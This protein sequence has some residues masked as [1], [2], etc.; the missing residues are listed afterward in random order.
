MGEE[1]QTFRVLHDGP[2]PID[3]HWTPFP[4]KGILATSCYINEYCATANAT[5]V[6]LGLPRKCGILSCSGLNILASSLASR[7]VRPL[8]HGL[9]SENREET[10]QQAIFG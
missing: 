2:L 1:V 9:F 5:F 3:S 4:E 8:L 7:F 10:T 6:P